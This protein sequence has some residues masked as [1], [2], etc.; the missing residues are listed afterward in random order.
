MLD[1]HGTLSI[2]DIFT[3]NF[4]F[5]KNK[6]EILGILDLVQG[7][8]V[9]THSNKVSFGTIH[10]FSASV[11]KSKLRNELAGSNVN[12]FIENTLIKPHIDS[13]GRREYLFA[14]VVLRY[15]Q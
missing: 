12:V 4:L 15:A 7:S 11:R 6:T 13:R 3:N 5:S 9:F 10:T 1:G 14:I 8:N 2:G